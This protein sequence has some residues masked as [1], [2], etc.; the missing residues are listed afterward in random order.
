ML[1]GTPLCRAFARGTALFGWQGKT[2][3]AARQRLVNRITP[4]RISAIAAEVYTGPSR[5]DGRDSIVLDYSKTS[6]VASWIRDEIRS[7]APQLYL[8]YAFWGTRRLITFSLD[9]SA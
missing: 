3:D 7:V 4:F 8:G 5:R 6:T 2:F 1:P 9:F